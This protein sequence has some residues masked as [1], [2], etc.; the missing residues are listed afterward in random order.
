MAG[1]NLGLFKGLLTV[2]I[3]SILVF[4]SIYFFFP[5]ISIKYFGIAFDKERAIE[6]SVASLLYK[7]SYF[8]DEEKDK[9]DEYLS[10]DEG[11]EFVKGISKAVEEGSESL[12]S[13]FS[14]ETFYSFRDKA[15]SILSEDSLKKLGQNI[16]ETTST[17]L[18][19]LK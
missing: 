19:S 6:D 14:S 10:S 1:K 11:K 15:Q 3:L 13:F 4:V 8:T 5:N 18:N 2:L 17:L 12:S 9:F 16:E 7:A